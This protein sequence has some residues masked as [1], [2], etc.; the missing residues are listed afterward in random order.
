MKEEKKPIEIWQTPDG[1]WT[2]E[3]HKKYKKP[4]GEEKNPYA[5]WFC[6]VKSPFTPQG[7][8]GDVYI[9]EIKSVAKLKKVI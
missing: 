7:E 3:V 9:S 4:K 8:W 5:R 6:K 1:S 2:W